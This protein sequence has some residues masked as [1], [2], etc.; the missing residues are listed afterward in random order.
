M[1]VDGQCVGENSDISLGYSRYNLILGESGAYYDAVKAVITTGLLYTN[2]SSKLSE[3]MLSSSKTIHYLNEWYSGFDVQINQA[4]CGLSSVATLMNSL[5]TEIKRLGGPD[6]VD[7][8]IDAMYAPYQY[9]TQKDLLEGS[10]THENVVFKNETYDSVMTFPYGTTLLQLSEVLECQLNGFLTRLPGNTERKADFKVEPFPINPVIHDLNW[11]RE[12]VIEALEKGGQFKG[13][14][15]VLVNFRR[16]E[17]GQRGGGHWSPIAAYNGDSDSV[18]ILD[19][20][21]YKYSP[22]WIRMEKLFRAVS[23]VDRCGIWEWAT[24]AQKLLTKE[25]REI[26]QD[27]NQGDETSARAKLECVESYRGIIRVEQLY[28]FV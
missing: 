17:L 27:G 25:E 8:P 20:A 19:T 2:S 13:S 14:M 16:S 4:Y 21:K 18:L 9:A 23:T 15:R 28:H 7:M 3:S 5:K 26:Y 6:H 12:T 11:F 22:T 1:V 24:N 10:C